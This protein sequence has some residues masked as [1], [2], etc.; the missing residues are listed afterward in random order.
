MRIISCINKEGDVTLPY[1]LIWNLWIPIVLIIITIILC[2]YRKDLIMSLIGLSLIGKGLLI[3]ITASA[4]YFMYY[5]S[6]YVIGYV[7][8]IFYITYCYTNRKK[9][10]LLKKNN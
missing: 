5:L 4:P 8:S 1:Y 9:H 7:Y 10:K 3:F 6:I 2:I